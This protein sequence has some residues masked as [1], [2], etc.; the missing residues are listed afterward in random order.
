MG[1]H[2][3]IKCLK[4]NQREADL[5]QLACNVCYFVKKIDFYLRNR[6]D[7]AWKCLGRGGRPMRGGPSLQG[8][9]V[10]K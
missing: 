9:K 8:S 10:S 1:N 2:C 5:V 6:S 7:L 3:L 4:K